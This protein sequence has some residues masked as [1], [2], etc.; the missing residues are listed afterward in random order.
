MCL[1]IFVGFFVLILL[2]FFLILIL[3]IL[4][5][6]AVFVICICAPKL[7][8]IAQGKQDSKDLV[9]YKSME[10]NVGPVQAKLSEAL[11]EIANL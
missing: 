2:F 1:Y 11:Q 4:L 9:S 3:G 5:G 8:C 6:D 7:M 10:E